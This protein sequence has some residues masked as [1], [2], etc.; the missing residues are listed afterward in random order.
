M[1]RRIKRTF[2]YEPC[3]WPQDSGDETP[4]D[5]F[6]LV[7]HDERQHRA[8]GHSTWLRGTSGD[9]PNPAHATLAEDLTPAELV[10]MITSAA[11][12]LAYRGE[13]S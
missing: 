11:D 13:D 6:K 2:T 10:G 4:P 9:G 12:W 5:T 8:Q 7:R 1:D 3:T